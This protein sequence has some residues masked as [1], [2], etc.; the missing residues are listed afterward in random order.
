M[1]MSINVKNNATYN[2]T[3][4]LNNGISVNDTEVDIGLME[5]TPGLEP[6]MTNMYYFNFYTNFSRGQ[7]TID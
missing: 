3:I 1:T 6:Y 5:T 4:V 7:V 2:G